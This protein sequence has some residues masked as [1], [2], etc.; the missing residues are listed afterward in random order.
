MALL[1]KLKSHVKFTCILLPNQEQQK[2]FY[3]IAPRRSDQDET[4]QKFKAKRA[5]FLTK[6]RSL[7][8]ASF[9]LLP[10]SSKKHHHHNKLTTTS[11]TE[12]NGQTR[13]KKDEQYLKEYR[14]QGELEILNLESLI[15]V[16]D[17]RK[18]MS[19]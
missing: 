11:S 18:R 8:L 4:D 2:K 7:S 3:S 1:W 13:E 14:A 9:K 16:N 15:N 5:V 6:G 12:K 10:S 19:K 17:V